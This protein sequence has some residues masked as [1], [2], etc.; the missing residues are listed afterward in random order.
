MV[1]LSDNLVAL[2]KEESNLAYFS[3]FFTMERGY[4]RDFKV[5]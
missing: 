2:I 5:T 3:S 4:F 1:I